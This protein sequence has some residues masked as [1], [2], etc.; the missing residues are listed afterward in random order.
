VGD[1]DTDP[2]F[3]FKPEMHDFGQKIVLGHLIPAGGGVEDANQ[4]LHILEAHPATAR[5]IAQKLVRRF[6][7]DEPSDPL[8]R[9]VADTYIA[10]KG[11]IRSMLRTI[12]ASPEFW[13][14]KA[15][16]AKARSPLEL[17]AA[18]VRALDA[19]VEDPLQLANWVARMGEPLYGAEPPFG[20]PDL[21]QTWLTPQ[22]LLAR[23]EYGLSLA[24]GQVKGVR[25]DLS[26]IAPGSPE[27]VLA[28]A[29]A[30]LGAG[31]L[32]QKTGAEILGQLQQTSQLQAA[33]AVG[34]LL[35]APELQR[36]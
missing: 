35:G 23:G 14:R 20:Y 33:R 12:F 32:S 24:S 29:T 28:E 21:A 36:R 16:H 6:V 26:G 31:D 11:D 3:A 27:Q 18:S 34:L 10:T 5:F 8:V 4:V 17:V 15:L 25:I 1:P 7:S 9:R 19:S 22:G 13:S 30:A 2:R